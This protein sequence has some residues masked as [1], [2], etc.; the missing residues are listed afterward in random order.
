MI[1]Y[2]PSESS[3]GV[4]SELVVG[5]LGLIFFVGLY[6]GDSSLCVGLFVGSFVG[7]RVTYCMML[8]DYFMF[9][10]VSMLSLSH[11]KYNI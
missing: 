4:G 3:L 1:H 6:V 9:I 2:N 8:L 11:T 10:I 5:F 7:P